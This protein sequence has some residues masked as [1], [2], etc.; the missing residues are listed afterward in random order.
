LNAYFT[1]REAVFF[2]KQREENP[3]PSHPMRYFTKIKLSHAMGWD[4]IVL[5]HSVDS[6]KF[7]KKS[8]MVEE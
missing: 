4:E 3:I 5:S 6:Q 2:I 1:G 8:I 7:S